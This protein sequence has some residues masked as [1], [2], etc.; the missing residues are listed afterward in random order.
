MIDGA[1]KHNYLD[2]NGLKLVVKN[3]KDYVHQE[4]TVL[5]EDILN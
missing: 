2:L 5:R 1:V 4:G 3:M